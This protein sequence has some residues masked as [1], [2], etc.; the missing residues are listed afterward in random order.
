MYLLAKLQLVL[1]SG[2]HVHEK[3]SYSLLVVHVFWNCTEHHKRSLIK[4]LFKKKILR[5]FSPKDLGLYC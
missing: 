4:M 5:T 1:V 2:L 3:E